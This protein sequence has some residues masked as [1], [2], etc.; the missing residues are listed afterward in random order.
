MKERANQFGKDNKSWNGEKDPINITGFRMIS[1][2]I[3]QEEIE[4]N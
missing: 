3:S 1:F 4:I 2:K